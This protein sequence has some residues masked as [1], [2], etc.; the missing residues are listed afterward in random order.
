MGSVSWVHCLLATS[1]WNSMYSPSLSWTHLSLRKN[2][3]LIT[4][5]RRWCSLLRNQCP[6]NSISACRAALASPAMAFLALLAK[7]FFGAIA[8]EDTSI[9]KIILHEIHNHYFSYPNYSIQEV[10]Q[11]CV[12]FFNNFMCYD[13]TNKTNH[14]PVCIILKERIWYSIAI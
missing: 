1:A 13:T 9:K 10:N 8:Y 7:S 11:F 4:S 5:K 6:S 14:N 12:G 3:P 2:Q